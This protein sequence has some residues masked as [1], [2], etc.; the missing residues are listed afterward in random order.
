MN[1]HLRVLICL[2]CAALVGL[3]GCS[4]D[5]E[6]SGADASGTSD[7]TTADTSGATTADTSG[8]TTAD[9]STT[10][11]DT[12]GVVE[13]TSGGGGPTYTNAVQAIYQANCTPCHTGA[14]G[15]SGGACFGANYADTQKSAGVCA[16]LTVGECT[17]MRIEN[18]SMPLGGGVVSAEDRAVI[19]AWITAGM[20]E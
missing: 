14:A 5:D 20:P 18:G 8:A 13:D 1:A 16:G 3:S 19:Q 17:L 7:T 10:E 9:T 4:E 15:C 11:A 12:S 6:K 2:L